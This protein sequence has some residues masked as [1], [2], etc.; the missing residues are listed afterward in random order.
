MSKMGQIKQMILD[1]LSDGQPHETKEFYKIAIERGYIQDSLD[2][3]IRNSLHH[4]ISKYPDIQRLSKGIYIMNSKSLYY[5]N[6]EELIHSLNYIS[7]TIDEM[8]SFNWRTCSDI[9]LAQARRASV[10]L[11]NLLEK[12]KNAF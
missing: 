3:T 12:L 5:Q 8:S 10:G 6:E 4:L 1:I 7:K 11:T 9:E 2:T